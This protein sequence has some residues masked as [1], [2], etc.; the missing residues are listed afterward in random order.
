MNQAQLFNEIWEERPHISEL[1][2]LPLLPKG[3][4]QWHWQFLHVLNKG[5]YTKWKENKENIIL[6]RPEEHKI[7]ERYPKFNEIHDRLKAKYNE[8]NKIQTFKN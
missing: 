6:A 3:H 5:T 7:Q 4:S 2:G 1:T 8:E